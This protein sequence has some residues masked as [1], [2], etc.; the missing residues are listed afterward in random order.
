[1]LERAIEHLEVL[2]GFDSVSEHPNGP[3]ADHLAG[4]LEGLGAQVERQVNGEKVN[5]WARLGP[6]GPGGVIL[7]AHMDVVP[8]AGQDWT[9]PPFAL[10]RDRG[11][12]YGR[13]SCDMKGF[14]AC[15]LAVLETAPPQVPIY[16]ALTHDE[17]VGCLGA[18][19]L[20]EWLKA[21][22]AHPALCLVGE[23]TEMRVIDAHKGCNE[24]TTRFTGRA[25]HGSDPDAGVNAAQYAARFAL[26]LEQI[27]AALPVPEDSPFTPPHTTLN[28]GAIRGG[29]AHNVIPETAEIAWEFR[30][31]RAD[32]A[33]QVRQKAE[34][35]RT[36]LEAEM[37][38]R[39]PA[40]SIRTD[41]IGEVVGLAPQEPHPMRDLM[42]SL[43]GENR[44][45]SVAFGTEAGL[46]QSLGAATVV[47]GPGS[48]AQA[49]KADEF[50]EESQMAACC[51]LLVRL[52]RR[53]A[54]DRGLV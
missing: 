8:V 15:V 29:S 25:G 53:L 4:V 26:G 52:L 27:A 47:C 9:H 12:L 6:D 28:I 31:V 48:I 2:V 43:T 40:C 18:Q 7:S 33:A 38:A 22:D 32:H 13:G 34:S 37:Q 10:T 16:V 11:R 46:F 35:L 24:Y 51:A 3:I 17:E 44:A 5:L 23:P 42:L 30:E 50:I 1:M 49:H 36:K 19:H 54:S 14:I 45:M 39:D 21:R 20:V 41:T